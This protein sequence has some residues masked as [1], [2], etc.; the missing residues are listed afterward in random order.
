MAWQNVSGA[1]PLAAAI[2]CNGGFGV[3]SGLVVDGGSPPPSGFA[4]GNASNACDFNSNS[5]SSGP[6]TA[7]AFNNPNCGGSGT[8]ADIMQFTAA[9]SLSSYVGCDGSYW[10]GN[11]LGGSGTYINTTGITCADCEGVFSYTDLWPSLPQPGGIYT[12]TSTTTGL[13]GFG[14]SGAGKAACTLRWTGTYLNPQC[15]FLGSSYITADGT[16]GASPASISAGDL[17][18]DETASEGALY[19][20]GSTANCKT[21]YG[22]TASSAETVGCAIN[23][24]GALTAST[25]ITDAGLSSSTSAPL[26]GASSAVI[27]QCVLTPSFVTTGSTSASTGTTANAYQQLGTT[28]SITTGASN[29]TNREWLVT[30]SMP[31]NVGGSGLNSEYVY[32]CISSASSF[33]TEDATKNGS[34]TCVTTLTNSFAGT[35]PFGEGPSTTAPTV[36][37]S[38]A[39]SAHLVVASNTQLSVKFEVAGSTATSA[40]VYGYGGITATPY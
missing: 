39:A 25:S 12:A 18:A 20:G 22:I 23:I 3:A 19:L 1:A 7:F 24:S 13:V 40:T 15:P 14:L 21:D 27:S 4:C 8:D 5:G 16:S 9:G 6:T 36:G 32:G 34:S 38:T 26:C 28:Q 10:I 11:P 30:I 37:L 29:G 17:S 2:Y 31:L 35:V 33:T